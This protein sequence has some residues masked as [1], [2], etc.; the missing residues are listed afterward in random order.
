MEGKGT[1][2]R[3]GMETVEQNAKRLGK[4]DDGGYPWL[5]ELSL[6]WLSWHPFL[7]PACTLSIFCLNIIH[8]LALK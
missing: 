7:I 8:N 4:W 1:E 3:D 6:L 5:K 2:S